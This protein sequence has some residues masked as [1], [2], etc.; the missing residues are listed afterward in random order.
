MLDQGAVLREIDDVVAHARHLISGS[1]YDDLSDL[2]LDVS[3]EAT[4]LLRSAIERFAPA[5]SAFVKNIGSATIY[6]GKYTLNQSVRPLLG[7]LSALR[8][9]YASGYLTSIYELVHAE[10][11][12]DFLEMASHLLENGY[13]D[14]AAV[15]TGSV[16]EEHLRKLAT[17]NNIGAVKP[18]GDPKTADALN[19]ELS[20]AGVYS[21]LDLKSI[22]GWLDLRNKAAH[23][24]YDEYDQR[25][26][27]LMLEGVKHF[28]SRNP[29]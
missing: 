26:V 8:L 9:S 29:A 16:L 17:K 13:K 12:A 27:M 19:G 15:V 24:R 25:Q 21:K 4:T 11:F 20:G 14:A 5:N 18:D 10:L 1:K 22:T 28:F 2:E 7:I 3:S 23:G 6:G